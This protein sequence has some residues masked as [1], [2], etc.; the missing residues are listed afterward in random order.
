[1][2]QRPRSKFGVVVREIVRL[3]YCAH[4][5]MHT[6]HRGCSS[7]LA[8]DPEIE[9]TA[10]SNRV[11]RRNINTMSVDNV[12][13]EDV[14]EGHEDATNNPPPL[15]PPPAPQ[16]PNNNNGNNGNN[17]NIGAPIIQPVQPQPNRNNCGQNGGNGGN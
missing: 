9:R 7:P 17:N 8:F 5:C 1:M 2:R 4:R 10:R 6:R 16:F 12:V 13:V 11:A 3:S 14:V 15:V